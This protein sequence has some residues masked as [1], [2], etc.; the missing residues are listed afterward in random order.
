MY[1]LVNCIT[2]EDIV[3]EN[4]NVFLS[5]GMV[6]RSVLKI[7]FADQLNVDAYKET[8]DSGSNKRLFVAKG[9]KDQMTPKRL[10]NYIEAKS[11]VP[12]KF[13]HDVLVLDSF[14]FISVSV[15]DAKKILRTFSGYKG[16]KPL[17]TRAHA[18]KN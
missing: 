6:A 18:T 17:V 16:Q 11:K 3:A 15:Q 9:K 2:P 1:F 8:A 4:N 13:I 14:S 10:V 7:A 12:A 5:S